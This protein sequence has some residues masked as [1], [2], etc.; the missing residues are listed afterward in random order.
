MNFNDTH[1]YNHTQDSFSLK[2][3]D[4]ELENRINNTIKLDIN[5]LGKFINSL[6]NLLHHRLAGFL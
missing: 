4:L 6:K 5:Y 1:H 3:D 2:P